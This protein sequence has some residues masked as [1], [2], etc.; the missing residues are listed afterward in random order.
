V[1]EHDENSMR[2][3]RKVLRLA[4]RER[5]EHIFVVRIIPKFGD[6]RILPVVRGRGEAHSRTALEE[7][8]MLEM[9]VDAGGSR[10]IPV[11]T[12]CI[13]GQFGTAATQ[14]AHRY[15]AD[16]LVMSSIKQ[17]TEIADRLYPSET[18]WGIRE[19]P[20]DIWIEG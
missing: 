4:A 13:E 14:F 20:C 3:Y 8:E 1:I 7:Q 15:K 19:A 18:K 5:A 12:F 9:F 16:L 11:Q 10:D 17:Y 6:A 2:V